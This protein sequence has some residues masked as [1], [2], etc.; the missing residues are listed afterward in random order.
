MMNIAQSKKV[1]ATLIDYHQ[2][3]NKGALSALRRGLRSNDQYKL[4]AELEVLWQTAAFPHHRDDILLVA[5]LYALH[6]KHSKGS[7]LGKVLA[8]IDRSERS[9]GRQL[10]RLTDCSTNLLHKRVSTVI[11]MAKAQ[12]IGVDY[13]S[14]LC[15]IT[16]YDTYRQTIVERWVRDY[17][18]ALAETQAKN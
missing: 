13:V 1:V 18:G 5:G 6:P 9:K 3:D 4:R 8:Q 14:I 16:Q 12:G 10:S 17:H 7:G 15:D 2:K 11:R